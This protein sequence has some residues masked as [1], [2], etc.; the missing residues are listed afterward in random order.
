MCGIAG[1]FNYGSFS[2]VDPKTLVQM[3]RVVS[4]RGP[5]DEGFF[6]GQNRRV[7]FGH[8]RL[9]I[10][11]LS[12]GHQPMSNADE[13]FWL[14]FNG[15]I[16][17]F[18]ELK[19][20]LEARNHYFRTSSDTEVIIHMYQEYG[21][22]GFDRLNGIF[23]FAIYDQ[24]K[25]CLIL[26]RD[27][28]GVKPLYYAAVNGSLI[29]GS[30]IKAILESE[31][32]QRELDF[33]SLNSFLTFR[34]NPSPQTM[35]RNIMR[36][37]PGNYLKVSFDV[38]VKIDTFCED[39]PVTRTNISEN[40]A[41]E[42]YQRLLDSA[43]HRQMISDVPIGLLLSGG[44]DSAA[45][46]FLMQRHSHE[47]IK[48]FSIGFSGNG[49]FN[50]LHDARRSAE[51]IGSDH[52]QLEIDQQ[53]YMEFFFKSFLFTEEPIAEPTIPALYYVCRLAAQHLKVVLAG[54]G[55]DE[56]LAGYPRYVGEYYLNKFAGLLR[57]LPLSTVAR[58]LPRN[59]RFKRAVYASQFKSEVERFLGIYTLFTREQ[60]QQLLSDDTKHKVT[61]VDQDLVSRLYSRSRMLSDPLSKILYIDTRMLLPD[62]LLLFNDKISMANSLEM[63]VPFLDLE[64]IKFLES[65]PS[66]FK[67]KGRKRK[68]IH[69]KAVGKWLP[70]EIIQRKKR[71][72]DTPMD[73]WLQSDLAD[74]AR[75]IVNAKDSFCSN[76]FMPDY[77]NGLIEK[78]QSRKENF[79]R[80]IFALL[81]LELWHKTFFCDTSTD[82]I[83]N[84]MRGPKGD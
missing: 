40:E 39:A 12:G 14:V 42:E 41:C 1:I 53:S 62:N 31:Y 67:L 11:D 2:P 73:T 83:A 4:H 5:D 7:G 19:K 58:F 52:Y 63:R 20:E 29:F 77:V 82:V 15:E 13:T 30:E 26:A 65:L 64:L 27:H 71:A 28:F 60:K 38:G 72:F 81:C 24:K 37:P 66:S 21:E 16:Y 45:I 8:R 34:Y 23:A 33:T 17:N 32:V 70:Q 9:S 56:P 75:R 57:L 76:Y 50:E 6:M 51:F 25:E 49:D 44:V 47:R 55:A 54:Q 36:L 69:K 74:T 10:I 35:F 22:K 78:H 84:M 59:E 3:T 80:H 79:R 48:T 61:D 46:G 43:V 18:R 68:Y